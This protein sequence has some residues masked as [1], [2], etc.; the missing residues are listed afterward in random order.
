[1]YSVDSKESFEEVKRLKSHITEAKERAQGLSKYKKKL[2]IPM[3]IVGNK[4]DLSDNGEVTTEDIH[5]LSAGCPHM[6]LVVSAKLNEGIDDIFCK[7]FHLAKLPTEMSPS[8]HRK[9]HPSY[10]AHSPGSIR[11][12]MTL[13]RRSSDV[14]AVAPNVRRPS[15]RTDLLIMQTKQNLMNGL[16]D[17]KNN[18]KCVIQ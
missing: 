12:T 1:M 15:I 7:L 13:R 3:V 16:D 11:R 9:V 4:S 8:L 2:P 10:V 6:H 14:G 17:G 18:T 5:D